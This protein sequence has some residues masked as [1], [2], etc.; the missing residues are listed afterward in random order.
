MSFLRPLL[1][2]AI[3]A[4]QRNSE[5]TAKSKVKNKADETKQ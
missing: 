2:F 4:Y 3:L 5:E 1:S